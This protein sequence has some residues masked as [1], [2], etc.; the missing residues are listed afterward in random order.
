MRRSFPLYVALVLAA[1]TLS[2]RADTLTTNFSVSFTG[3][4]GPQENLFGIT[5]FDPRLGTLNSITATLSGY[6]SFV[7]QSPGNSFYQLNLTSPYGDIF[8]QNYTTSSVIA[9][10]TTFTNVGGYINCCVQA[11][12]H[13]ILDPDVSITAGSASTVA[14]GSSNVPTSLQGTFTYNYT[15]TPTPEPSTLVLLSSGI[16]ATAGAVRKRLLAAGP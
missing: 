12:N 9:I 14:S 3:L 15:P 13:L 4:T 11:V 7:P 16:L 8:R 5:E 10:S 2:A 6:V 1:A